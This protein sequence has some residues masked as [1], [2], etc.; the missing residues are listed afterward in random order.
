M[1]VTTPWVRKMPLAGNS[2]GGLVAGLETAR[3]FGPQDNSMGGFNMQGGNNRRG[4]GNQA[5]PDTGRAMPTPGGGP[6]QRGGG[7]EDTLKGFDTNGNSMIDADEVAANPIAKRVVEGIFS[8]MGK[9]P[10]YPVSISELVQGSQLAGPGSRG[11]SSA[12]AG[13]TLLPGMGFGSPSTPSGGQSAATTGRPPFA[14]PAGGPAG[15]PSGMAASAQGSSA[16]SASDATPTRKPTRFLSAREK[17]R[18]LPSWFTNLDT[19]GEGQITMAQ[20]ATTWTP[21]TVAAF[22]RYDLNHDGIITA[23]EVMKVEGP[24]QVRGRPKKIC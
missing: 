10:H 13:L 20:Y 1:G 14:G 11:G 19:N 23:E 24:G 2:R 5:V 21:E 12:G 7:I 22:N 4:R 15:P 6:V 3:G 17:F 18:G 9:E 16:L 8:R